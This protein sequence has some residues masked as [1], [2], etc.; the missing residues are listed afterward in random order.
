MG[1]IGAFSALFFGIWVL[2]ADFRR[3]YPVAAHR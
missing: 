1:L 2:T 3:T